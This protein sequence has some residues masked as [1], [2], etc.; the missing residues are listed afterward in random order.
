MK[1]FLKTAS[2]VVAALFAVALV[3]MGVAS[4]AFAD[5]ATG[6][7]TTGTVTNTTQNKSYD[8][9]TA[10]IKEAND[11]DT[12]ELGPGNYTTYCNRPRHLAVGKSLT[13]VG[14]GDDT[15]WG[16]GA[17]YPN[18]DNFGTEYNSDYSFKGSKTITFRNMTLHSAEADYLGFT[19][20][21]N[22]VVDNC[23]VEGKTFFWGYKTAVFKN[24]RF[25]PPT[26]DYAL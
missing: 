19:Y 11:N 25:N 2:R 14:S 5:G 20:I 7:I 21:D 12:I 9:L 10:A 13:F 24:T 26:G 8:N 22:T 6:P 16:I 23:L 18:P 1:S 15:I 3:T 17:K 4:P